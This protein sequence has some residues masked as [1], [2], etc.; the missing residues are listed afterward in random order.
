VECEKLLKE[1]PQY[2]KKG[3]FAHNIE[4]N[5]SI[6]PKV[7][8]LR[9]RLHS[10]NSKILILLKPLELTLL[11]EI[12][13]DL[14]ERIDAV[15][16]SVRRLE[17]LL[18]QNVEQALSEQ[19]GTL[20]IPL[21]VPT[22]IEKKFQTAAEKSKPEIRTRGNFPLQAGA[23]AFV[24]HFEESTT[25]FSAA[26]IF[27]NERTPPSKQYLSLLKCIWI[28]SRLRE[29]DALRNAP[30]DSQW[31]GYIDQLNENLSVECQKFTTPSAKRL[32][33][34]N[35]SSL[36]NADEYNI[37]PGE[38]IAEYISLHF[39]RHKEEVLKIPMPSPSE[40]VK[41]DITIY[42]L[43]P[44]KFRLVESVEDKN[45]LSTLQERKVD[46]DL[47]SVMLTPIYATPSLTPKPFAVQIH[48]ADVIEPTF[49]KLDHV[50]ALQHLLTGYKVYGRYDQA[51]DKVSFVFSDQ[52]TREY[53][54]RLQLWL[55]YPFEASSTST[56]LMPSEA[57]S[58]A[59]RSQASISTA[60]E[61]MSNRRG[62]KVSVVKREID[63]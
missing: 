58:P 32:I 25:Q 49:R 7:D 45:T 59:S 16:R 5:A 43:E 3:N 17:G 26:G 63:S 20:P 14:V 55:P 34:P 15:Q 35:L 13:Y 60:V 48:S 57:Q 33:E 47:E 30:N 31:H 28:M 44:T 24:E 2:G 51:M 4:W 23:D 41:C 27:I 8:R 50:L 36:E 9:G 18:I 54:G 29:S 52:A 40:Q 10:H 62:S 37:W 22:N 56:S 39:E 42:Q 38:N 6:Q 19:G 46:I 61:S 53:Y 11:R 21:L 12:H 1:N